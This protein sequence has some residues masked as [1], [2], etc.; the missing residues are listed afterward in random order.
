VLQHVSDHSGS[1]IREPRTVYDRIILVI[2]SQECT[3]PAD[4][5]SSMIRNMLEHFQIFYYFNFIY[6]LDSKVFNYH[7]CTVQTWRFLIPL[8][9]R[10][11]WS[12]VR[13]WCR[14]DEYG[15]IGKF[16]L[17]HQTAKGTVTSSDG[18]RTARNSTIVDQNSPQRAWPACT[19]RL[20]AARGGQP[21]RAAQT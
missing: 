20:T 15:A 16:L 18:Q 8:L 3:R 9:L 2:F 5:G 10:Q 19:C 1:I 7:W 14:A 6:Y 21:V 12:P 17:G 13:V 11:C 4:D